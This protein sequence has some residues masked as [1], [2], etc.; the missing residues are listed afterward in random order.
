MPQCFFQ[1]SI[2]ALS[3]AISLLM[4]C[5]THGS[6]NPQLDADGSVIVDGVDCVRVLRPEH[7]AAKFQGLTIHGLCLTAPAL[8]LDAA[9]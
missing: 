1:C 8:S 2:H 3:L 6:L 5:G 7:L 4:E 9:D